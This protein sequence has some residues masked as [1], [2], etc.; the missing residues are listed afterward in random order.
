MDNIKKDIDKLEFNIPPFF[1]EEKF[2]INIDLLNNRKT[3]EHVKSDK[4]IEYIFKVILG[5]FSKRRKKPTYRF[6][7]NRRTTHHWYIL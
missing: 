6:N 5:T 1:Q 7:P 2:K 4:K 3:I